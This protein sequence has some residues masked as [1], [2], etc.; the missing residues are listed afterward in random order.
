MNPLSER[1]KVITES[2]LFNNFIIG[3]I[4]FAGVLVGVETYPTMEEKYGHVLHTLDAIVLWIFVI[5]VVMKMGAQGRRPWRYFLDP[6]NVFDFVIVVV[7]FLPATGPYA[8][9]LRLARLFRVLRLVRF[10]PRLQI[11]V[12]ALLKSLPSMVYV[13]VLLGMIFYMYAV[14][15]TFLFGKN[16]PVHFGTLH[17]SMLSLFRIVTLE[18]WTDIMY[19][20][21]HGCDVYGY[22][23]REYLCTQPEAFPLIGPLYFVSFV[24]I[25]TM[26]V[27][28]L[29]IGVIMSGMDEATAEAHRE[30]VLE[31]LQ[32]PQNLKRELEGLEQALEAVQEQLGRVQ[33]WAA[34]Y[35]L[36]DPPPATDGAVGTSEP[37]DQG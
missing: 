34:K 4:L 7:C 32:G 16:D 13:S 1:L 36:P 37:K 10:I 9:V 27:L 6:W 8:L 11:L 28:N 19:T 30:M 18:D 25:G 31:K 15:G 35:P 22:G 23:F 33:E 2:S 24:L 21:M 17:Q 3:V 26:I 20:A 12:S 14:A 29:F 5:E